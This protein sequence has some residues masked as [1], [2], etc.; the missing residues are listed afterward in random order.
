MGKVS[1]SIYFMNVFYYTVN[2]EEGKI[3][4]LINFVDVALV[5]NCV[6]IP[7]VQYQKPALVK[8]FLNVVIQHQIYAG[9]NNESSK[10][11]LNDND[12]TNLSKM[13]LRKYL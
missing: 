11:S 8:I 3:I 13:C 4:L 12:S 5:D 10:L 1:S 6:V 2:C 9:T 7:G